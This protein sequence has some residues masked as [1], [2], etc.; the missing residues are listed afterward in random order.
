MILGKERMSGKWCHLCQLS[1]RDFTD[2]VK[3]VDERTNLEMK[4]SVK[5]YHEK[6]E[7]H[8]RKKTKTDPKPTKGM[9]EQF[10]WY[11]IPV[12]H[13]VVPLLHCLIGIGGDM[14]RL[15]LIIISE[16]I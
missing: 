13:F 2:L 10:W 12:T 4:I 5:E 3:V 1:G 9:K 11:F 16:Y 7:E 8:K 14:F 15:F 6:I